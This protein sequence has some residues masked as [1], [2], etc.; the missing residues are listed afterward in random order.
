MNQVSILD[1]GDL[2]YRVSLTPVRSPEDGHALT[3][4]SQR[5]ASRN[6]DE[7]QVRFFACLDR[8]GLQALAN[9]LEVV[10]ASTTEVEPT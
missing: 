9:L 1:N 8:D 5:R 3:I 4:T 7:Q 10:L 6:P 2:C